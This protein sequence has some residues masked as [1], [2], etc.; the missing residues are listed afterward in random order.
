MSENSG[1][2]DAYVGVSGVV[3]PEQQKHIQDL[4]ESVNLQE[5]RPLDMSIVDNYLKA[6]LEA[7]I[8]H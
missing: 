8:N 2:P 1:R 6:S 5:S 7:T 4:A 3:N